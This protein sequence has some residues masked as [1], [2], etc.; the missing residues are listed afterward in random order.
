M[1]KEWENFT[2]YEGYIWGCIQKF[3]DWGETHDSKK[4]CVKTDHVHPATCNL[5]YCLT[6]H[7]SPTIYW[8]Y[9][10]P[11]LLYSW[12]HQSGIFWM[13]PRMYCVS[14]PKLSP[15][16]ESLTRYSDHISHS[17]DECHKIIWI[18]TKVSLLP[19]QTVTVSLLGCSS[20]AGVPSTP[21]NS[22][23]QTTQ[24]RTRNVGPVFALTINSEDLRFDH[25]PH[26]VI[27]FGR[28]RVYQWLVVL[29][30]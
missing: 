3:P 1:V 24:T 6:I 30:W 8:C 13:Y 26:L 25:C 10:L 2:L 28:G 21:H 7:C 18:E 22:A 20:A 12:R 11:Q 5:A 17:S 16:L 19:H 27:V 4:T 23:F 29:W 9:A 15:K 14:K